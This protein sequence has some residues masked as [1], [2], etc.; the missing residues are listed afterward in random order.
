MSQKICFA[1]N[2]P[3]EELTPTRRNDDIP[4]CAEPSLVLNTGLM[5]QQNWNLGLA[6][7]FGK[8]SRLNKGSERLESKVKVSDKELQ[9]K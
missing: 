1:V 9:I 4:S 8:N 6:G 7:I 5:N 3:I 2:R